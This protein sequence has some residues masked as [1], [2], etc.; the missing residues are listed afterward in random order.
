M[1]LHPIKHIGYG[2]T[3]GVQSGDVIRDDILIITAYLNQLIQVR[4]TQNQ[5]YCLVSMIFKID[6][7]AFAVSTLLK[8]IN[9]GAAEEFPKYC[10]AQFKVKKCHY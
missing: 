3:S 8:K 1:E 2:H 5:F 10:M 9:S 4:V 7:R 6:S